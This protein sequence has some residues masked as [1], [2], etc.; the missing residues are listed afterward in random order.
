MDGSMK[1]LSKKFHTR[2]KTIVN[3]KINCT[4][5]EKEDK[6]H[7]TINR[8][9]LQYDT[10]I[11]DISGMVNDE[12]KFERALDIIVKRIRQYVDHKYFY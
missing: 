5:D 3:A 12:E 4:I 9:G 8:L 1:E 2:L 11:S 10:S 6:L 7:V